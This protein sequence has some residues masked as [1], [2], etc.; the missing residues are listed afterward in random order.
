[1]NHRNAVRAVLMAGV[2]AG[3]LLAQVAQARHGDE[4]V[5]P[6][7]IPEPAPYV[8]EESNPPGAPGAMQAAVGG[9]SLAMRIRR[10]LEPTLPKE[11]VMK[12]VIVA[13]ALLAC[14][15]AGG[16]RLELVAQEKSEPKESPDAT[17]IVKAE[18]PATDVPS[19][20]LTRM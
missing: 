4:T 11:R 2:A 12:R 14:L 20:R 10:L 18:Q 5:L 8:V 19:L 9:R 6:N 3:A 1:M 15:A 13:A 7:R 17:E 16:V